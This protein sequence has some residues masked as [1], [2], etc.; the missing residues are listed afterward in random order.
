MTGREK[1]HRFVDEPTEDETA[2]AR[3]RHERKTVQQWAQTED[4]G[5][6]D[7]WALANACEAVREEPW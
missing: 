7:T 2:L 5:A 6:E 4:A 3:L 1:L